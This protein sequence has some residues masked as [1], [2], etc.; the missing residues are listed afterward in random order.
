MN[1]YASRRIED[2]LA[3]IP[4][5]Y[6]AEY[7]TQQEVSVQDLTPIVKNG[8]LT[9]TNI[10]AGDEEIE[11][12]N[13]AATAGND[14][15]AATCAIGINR[16]WAIA[17]DDGMAARL[18]S[19]GTFQHQIISTPDIIKLWIDTTVPTRVQIRDVLL[20]IQSASKYLPPKGHL[21]QQWWRDF[22]RM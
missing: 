11:L 4:K 7:Y 21:L 8:L 20:N 17:T 18:L 9:P 13:Y 16:G 5:A 19:Q 15:L 12:V 1:L 22:T 2:I 3:S 14:S 6:I 10:L